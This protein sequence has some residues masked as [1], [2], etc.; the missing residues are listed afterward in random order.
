MLSRN[1]QLTANAHGIGSEGAL[2]VRCVGGGVG[3]VGKEFREVGETFE[4]PPLH[5]SSGRVVD[6]AGD[7]RG[8][9]SDVRLER[10]RSS[11]GHLRR[12][13]PLEGDLALH[14]VVAS[15]EHR[16]RVVRHS[17]CRRPSW[18]LK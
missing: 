2:V 8:R 13:V 9:G 3:V 12:D 14:R 1:K 17:A 16:S 6:P 11:P 7:G 18:R 15:F 5:R 10:I 4:A